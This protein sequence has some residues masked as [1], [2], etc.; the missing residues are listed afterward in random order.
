VTCVTLYGVTNVAFHQRAERIEN[1]K[2]LRWMC[3][4]L[5][6]ILC[7]CA[8]SPE[9]DSRHEAIADQDTHERTVSVEKSMITVI[10]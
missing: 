9:T 3:L 1:M 8:G 10:T 7:S 4:I 5:V 6:L 2:R